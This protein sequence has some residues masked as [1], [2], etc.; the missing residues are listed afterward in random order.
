MRVLDRVVQVIKA[1]RAES[2]PEH[3]RRYRGMNA[4]VRD[5]V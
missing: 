1:E 4:T 2:R 3:K 5:G